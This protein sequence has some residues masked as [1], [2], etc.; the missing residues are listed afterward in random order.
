MSKLKLVITGLV[1]AFIFVSCN[2]ERQ[3]SKK[4]YRLHANS[5]VATARFCA[6]VYPP[7]AK[8][9]DTVMY[10]KGI[11]VIQSNRLYTID[12]D[13]VIS[14]S[15]TRTVK[16]LVGDSVTVIDTLVVY[17]ERQL[18]NKANEKL[19]AATNE[20]LRVSVAKYKTQRNWLVKVVVVL[21][22]FLL[23]KWLL[24]SFSLF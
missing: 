11:P 2:T 12:C 3:M 5:N 18:V 13:S 21:L 10:K 15:K 22:V 24:K 17:K 1:L 16:V 14:Q 19:L 6:H 20:S 23:V 4:L 7:I 8:V 9:I